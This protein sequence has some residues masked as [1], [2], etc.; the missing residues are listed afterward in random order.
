MKSIDRMQAA[1]L[2]TACVMAMAATGMATDIGVERGASRRL[3]DGD[4]YVLPTRELIDVGQELF[5]ASWTVQEGGGRPLTKGTGAPLGDPG[6]P[7]VFPFNFNRVSAPDA[8][9]CLGCHN[10]PFAGGGGD[11]VA[12]VFVLGQRFDFATFDPADQAPLR[13]TSD[14]RGAGATLQDIGN[15]RGSIGMF[16]SGYIELLARQMTAEL[17]RQRDSLAPGQSRR[18]LASGVAFGRLARRPDG[19]FDVSRV[20][21][22]PRP[23]LEGDIPD[24]VLRPFHQ[25]GAVVSIRQFTNNALNH[26]HG[27]QPVERFG[28]GDPDGDG[29]AAEASRADVTALSVFQATLPVPARVIPRDAG[30]RAAIALGEHRF[31]EVGCADCHRPYLPLRSVR[32]SEPNP[33]NPAGNL[34]PNEVR[35]PLVIDL[36][37][38]DLPGVRLKARRSGRT[39][40]PAFTDLKLHTIYEPGSPNCEPL[41]QSNGELASGSCAFVT[42]KLWGAYSEPGFGHHGQYTTMREAI[43]AHAG[44]AAPVMRGWRGLP[45]LERS[46]IIEFLKT[47]RTVPAH[48]KAPVVDERMRPTAWRAFPYHA[49]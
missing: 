29:H 23:G 17:Q 21:G 15:S 46:A 26:H 41:N 12:N 19:S 37:D 4:E 16:G 22:L 33:F 49:E 7:L 30:V 9:S 20:E 40:V 27:I 31:V 24:F 48:V 38:P 8:N 14:E 2:A 45:D 47:L 35:R 42:R 6:R 43:E 10:L 28:S 25:A 5:A 1:V 39:L 11:F 32:Y 3:A 36:N 44:E 34:R 13:G 18:L